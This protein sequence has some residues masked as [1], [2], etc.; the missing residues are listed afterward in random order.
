[1]PAY[2]LVQVD[3]ND[4]KEYDAY[5]SL[6]PATV[7]SFGGRFIIRGNPIQVMEG[8]WNH[9]RLVMIEFADK[10]TAEDWY[11]SDAYQAAKAIRE[12]ASNANFFIIEV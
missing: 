10:K 9:D 4:P 11:H 2:V 8:E 3:I 1:M 7:E 12:P 5:K 6:T